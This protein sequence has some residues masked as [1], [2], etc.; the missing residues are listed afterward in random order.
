M[1]DGMAS[2]VVWRVDGVFD[3]KLDGMRKGSV[4]GTQMVD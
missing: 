1:D 2:W 4:P 3:G